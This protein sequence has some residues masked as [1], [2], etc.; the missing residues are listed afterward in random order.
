[1]VVSLKILINAK[2]SQVLMNP[3]IVKGQNEHNSKNQRKS[4]DKEVYEYYYLDLEKR[5]NSSRHH[6][7]YSTK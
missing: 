3:R 1:M 7:H 6:V 2:F 4:L 5:L